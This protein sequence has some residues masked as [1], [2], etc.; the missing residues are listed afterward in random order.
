MCFDDTNTDENPLLS[1]CKCKGDTKWVH[2]NCLKKWNNSNSGEQVCL[3]S[4]RH[5]G[6]HVCT[7]CKASYKTHIKLKNG[8]IITPFRGSLPY[9]FISFLVVTRHESA[10]NLFSTKFQLS[11]AR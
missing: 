2:L 4:N 7:V 5:S 9:P 6:A 1:P 3:V 11:F 8:E 10:E